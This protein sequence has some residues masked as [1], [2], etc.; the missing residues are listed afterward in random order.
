MTSKSIVV[1]TLLGL[2]KPCLIY[3][4]FGSYWAVPIEYLDKMIQPNLPDNLSN[5]IDTT[6]RF[7][8]PYKDWTIDFSYDIKAKRYS[9]K[10]NELLAEKLPKSDLLQ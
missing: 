2:V 5:L 10:I 9:V 8:H 4:K 3:F 7:K 6:V 1:L